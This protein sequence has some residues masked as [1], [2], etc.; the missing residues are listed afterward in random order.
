MSSSGWPA[1]GGCRCCLLSVLLVQQLSALFCRKLQPF[2]SQVAVVANDATVKGGT[3]YPITGGQHACPAKDKRVEGSYRLSNRTGT[4][5]ACSRALTWGVKGGTSRPHCK[6]AA[7]L[8]RQI[9]PLICAAAIVY[10]E[11]AAS[12][13]R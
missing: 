13:I 11:A 5:S 8:L 2:L 6:R 3:Y 4:S 7:C 1:P 9:A 12:C 10:R